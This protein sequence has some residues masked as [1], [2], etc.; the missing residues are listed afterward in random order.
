MPTPVKGRQFAYILCKLNGMFKQADILQCG[1]YIVVRAF[2]RR[3]SYSV[4]MT[5]NKVGKYS[6]HE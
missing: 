3:R 6:L 4:I 2:Q 1:E 5:K